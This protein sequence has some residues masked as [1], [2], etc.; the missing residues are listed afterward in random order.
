MK[1]AEG[2]YLEAS[3]LRSVPG[4]VDAVREAWPYTG[5][6]EREGMTRLA[7]ESAS[8]LGARPRISRGLEGGR[9]C[10]LSTEVA[11]DEMSMQGW[12]S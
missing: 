3:E 4:V 9:W 1:V 6:P 8:V 11:D 5:S 7:L 10:V 2:S 12:C